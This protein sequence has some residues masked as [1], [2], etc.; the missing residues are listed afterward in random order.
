MQS[1]RFA[2]SDRAIVAS[3]RNNPRQSMANE[4]V[5]LFINPTAGRGKAGRRLGRIESILDSEGIE[6]Q[7]YSSRDV[8]DLEQLVYDSLERDSG[9]I[10]VAG[11]DGSIHEAVNGI[12][13]ARNP[14]R[15]AVIPTGTGN[16]FAK[17][18]GLS[19]DWELTA[20][21]LA[22]RIS[23]RTNGRRISRRDPPLHG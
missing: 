5:S 6:F 12:M 19:L 10:V 11:G 22:A 20:A 13:R 9:D 16:D 15:L 14:G 21:E 2:Q 23:N 8:G 3:G 18:C 4:S 1:N 7:R 17:A